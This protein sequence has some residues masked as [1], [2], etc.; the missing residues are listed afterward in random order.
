MKVDFQAQK[1]LDVVKNSNKREFYELTLAEARAEYLN[2][3]NKLKINRD[4]F[5]TEDIKIPNANFNIPIRVYT[6]KILKKKEKLPILVWYHGGGFVLGSIETHDSICRVLSNDSECIVF[7]VGYRLA[8]EHKFPIAIED[9]FAAL[10]WITINGERFNADTKRIS[11]GGDSAGAN[12]A[13]VVSLLARDENHPVI[14]SQLLIYPCTAP[15]PVSKSQQKFSDGYLLTKKL[16]LWFYENYKR[17]SLDSNDF[18]FAPLICED[19]TNLPPALIL[20]AGFDPLRD[21]G[22]EYTRKLVESGNDV[23]LSN[24]EGMIH[25]FILM[26]NAIEKAH[27]ALYE[28]SEYLKNQFSKN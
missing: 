21:E 17:N 20:T 28:C 4:I 18:R 13:T 7:S 14:S 12:I 27:E 9:S 2:R 25:G 22:I 16:I 15:E 10:R 23:K 19:L 5:K 8:P 11:L 3:T 26:G 1:V 6:P 24:Y